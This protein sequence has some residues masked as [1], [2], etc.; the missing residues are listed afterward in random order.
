MLQTET[1][2]G[3]AMM[4]TSYKPA[5]IVKIAIGS[6]APY[7]EGITVWIN[8]PQFQD[9]VEYVQ[10][11]PKVRQVIRD[12][13]VP[14]NIHYFRQPLLEHARS[15][16]EETGFR[17]DYLIYTDDDEAFPEALKFPKLF[18]KW[19]RS[20]SHVIYFVLM[21]HWRDPKTIRVDGKASM[22]NH[23]KVVKYTPDL[24]FN[25]GCLPD[26]IR[27]IPQMWRHTWN[28]P[29]PLRHFRTMTD[30]ERATYRK[31]MGKEDVPDEN[32]G[33]MKRSDEG[34]V[35]APYN[36]EMTTANFQAVVDRVRGGDIPAN[37]WTGEAEAHA[38]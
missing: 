20:N 12:D 1:H 16:W 35:M 38:R 34:V 13:V 11:H 2:R 32:L 9:T 5:H 22:N 6:I 8:N 14:F 29:W 25:Y 28:C 33:V 15:Y 24:K 18:T 3:W 31:L 27:A 10:S 19:I 37:C 26:N 4:A 17:P 30:S 23:S 21:R 7:V 36:P